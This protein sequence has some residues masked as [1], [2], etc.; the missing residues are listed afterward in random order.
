MENS[1]FTKRSKHDTVDSLNQEIYE[2]SNT[3]IILNFVAAAFKQSKR[4]S[5][6]KV[7][8]ASKKA[9]TTRILGMFKEE[10]KNKQS[11]QKAV[12]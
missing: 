9:F 12:R 7:F 5:E 11:S 8:W 3:C 4:I 2:V 6:G 1:E 10:E